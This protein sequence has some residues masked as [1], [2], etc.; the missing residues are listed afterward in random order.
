MIVGREGAI[1]EINAGS[2]NV[3]VTNVPLGQSP[4]CKQGINIIDSKTGALEFTIGIGVEGA[5][6]SP[7]LDVRLDTCIPVAARRHKEFRVPKLAQQ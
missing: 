1:I 3:I 7:K 2:G 4:H 6:T 5:K